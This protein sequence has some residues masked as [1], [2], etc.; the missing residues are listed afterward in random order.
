MLDAPS[1]SSLSGWVMARPVMSAR[2]TQGLV[3]LLTCRFLEPRAML[4]TVVGFSNVY[5]M[6]VRWRLGESDV[7]E[8]RGKFR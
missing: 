8:M 6:K 4:S 5:A 2:I 3:A 7:Y 1:W